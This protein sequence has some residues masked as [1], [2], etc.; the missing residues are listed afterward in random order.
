MSVLDS[1]L[2][3]LDDL[4]EEALANGNNMSG[5]YMFVQSFPLL[6]SVLFLCFCWISCYLSLSLCAL[7]VFVCVYL[8]E[9]GG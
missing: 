9:V 3:V 1:G 6:P 8:E 2:F 4:F 7:C 5:I